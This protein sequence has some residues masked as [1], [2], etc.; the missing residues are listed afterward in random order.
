MRVAIIIFLTII[1]EVIC[2]YLFGI[3]PNEFSLFMPLF[4]IVLI[5]YLYK[6]FRH[7][8]LN[9]FLISAFIGLVYG[10]VFTN[11]GIVY[12]LLYLLVAFITAVLASYF[13]PHY[14][15]NLMIGGISIT[16]VLL[17]S[18]SLLIIYNVYY[19]NLINFVFGMLSGYLLN[20]VYLSLLTFIDYKTTKKPIRHL[21]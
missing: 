14:L 13:K 4:S 20:F 12:V 1:L 19:F 16:L 8:L 10:I 7:E 18:Y 6:F 21:L 5:V 15:I 9:Y 17:L 2:N 3:N 11:T